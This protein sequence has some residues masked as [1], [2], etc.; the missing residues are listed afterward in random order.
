MR[1]ARGDEGNIRSD[2]GR[3][4]EVEGK[5]VLG[6]SGWRAGGGADISDVPGEGGAGWLGL[7]AQWKNGA[8]R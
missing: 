7:T 2:G 4:S 3:R 5:T 8:R 1:G 6:V